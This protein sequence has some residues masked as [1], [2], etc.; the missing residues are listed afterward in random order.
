MSLGGPRR[1]LA[2]ARY[3]PPVRSPGPAFLRLEQ[4]LRAGL[5][6]GLG[7]LLWKLRRRQPVDE[8]ARAALPAARA[9]E[10]VTSEGA[11][12]ALTVL[13]AHF[14]DSLTEYELWKARGRRHHGAL[15]LAALQSERLHGL[16]V[17]EVG[18]GAGVNLLSLQRWAEVVGVDVEPL[19]LQLGGLLARV[20]GLHAPARLCARAEQLPFA[21]GTFD[22]VLFPGSLP[23]MRIERALG[24]AARV[25]RPGGRAIAVQSDLDQMLRLRLGRWRWRLLAPL[26]CARELRALAGMAAYPLCG[27]SFLPGSAPVHLGARRMERMLARC[28]LHLVR[29]ESVRL[30]DEHCYVAEKRAWHVATRPARSGW[31]L[32]RIAAPQPAS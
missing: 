24:E 23:Y 4:A 10:L 25:L 9:L 14:S 22:V 20:E 2:A 6:Q 31:R 26:R 30:A 29:D 13:G 19:Y 27:R 32:P 7:E 1:F 3:G 5:E 8:L 15:E 21:D 18:C 28:G 11:A 17:L 16:Q 12:P